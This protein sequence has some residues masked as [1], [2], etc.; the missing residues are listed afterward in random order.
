MVGLVIVDMWSQV[1]VYVVI[2]DRNY[3]IFKILAYIAI[4]YKKR[5]SYVVKKEGEKGKVGGGGRPEPKCSMHLEKILPKM[6]SIIVE[7]GSERFLI[8]SAH[9]CTPHAS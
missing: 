2:N 4:H 7:G 3:Y 6:V 5:C 1:L 9:T 8:T